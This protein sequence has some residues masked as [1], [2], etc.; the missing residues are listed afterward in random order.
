M[1]HDSAIFWL[2]VA[3]VLYSVGLL[4]A[5]FVLAR[6][7]A[8]FFR[9]ALAAFTTAALFHFVSVVETTM[10]VGRLPVDNFFEAVSFCALL[11]SAAFLLLYWRY[12]FASLS[13]FIFPLVYLMSQIGAMETPVASWPSSGVRDA[14]LFAHV[15]AVLLGYVGLL[16]T[17][18]AS[19][20]YLI[21]E[22]QLKSKRPDR[23]FDRLPPLATLDNLIT[24]SMAFGFVFI[25]I[26]VIA[27]SAWAF[28]ESGTSWISD[29]KI[30]ISLFTWVFCLLM[31]FLR[32]S[33]G[34]RGRKAAL[35]AI[36]VLG[37]SALTWAAHV[38]LRSLIIR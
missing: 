35:M 38:G 26:G 32:A 21:Q 27:G 29:P 19:I 30:A 23:F 11:I 14:W 4:H 36:T 13:L 18:L 10:A 31:V 25:T 3:T 1:M 16:V 33:A 17:A 5:I 8:G 37:C 28:I 9:Y 22:R 15:A 20:F 24:H 34:L 2:R 7:H 6:R 12:H